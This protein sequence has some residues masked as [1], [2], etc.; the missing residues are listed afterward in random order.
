VFAGFGLPRWGFHGS[1]SGMKGTT[2]LNNVISQGQPTRALQAY[3]V[4]DRVERAGRKAES[5][6]R[7][8]LRGLIR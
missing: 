3:A 6:E 2:Y 8:L 4:G 7:E 1:V 5:G